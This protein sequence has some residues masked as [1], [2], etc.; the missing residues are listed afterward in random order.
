MPV[1]PLIGADSR[2]R[3]GAEVTVIRGST[4]VQ[5]LYKFWTQNLSISQEAKYFNISMLYAG[6]H[7][8]TT[9]Q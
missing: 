6:T 8:F 2:G 7:P 1:W 4:V 9:P 3:R 5:N